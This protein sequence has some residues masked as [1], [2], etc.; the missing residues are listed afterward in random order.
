M[1]HDIRSLYECRTFRLFKYVF[2]LNCL[3]FE[4]IYGPVMDFP[5][6]RLEVLD[7][8]WK[9]QRFPQ[10]SRPQKLII[11]HYDLLN[12]NE[13]S[14]YGIFSTPSKIEHRMFV[15]FSFTQWTS[16]LSADRLFYRRPVLALRT[17]KILNAQ[18]RYLVKTALFFL[19]KVKRWNSDFEM[20]KRLISRRYTAI[21]IHIFTLINIY[22]VPYQFVQLKPSRFSKIFLLFSFSSSVFGI[23]VT[24]IVFEISETMVILIS[25]SWSV[26]FHS[27]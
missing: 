25:M 23:M 12:I 17:H 6:C 27:Q 10:K 2:D 15:S 16:P 7:T 1:I 21:F 8:M 24:F 14:N 22:T 5:L 13:H 4:Y 18:Y 3:T 19:E 20:K 9:I 26:R 11:R